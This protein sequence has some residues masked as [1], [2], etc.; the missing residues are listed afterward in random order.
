MAS[1]DFASCVLK[2]TE[3]Y[4]QHDKKTAGKLDDLLKRLS[5]PRNSQAL[6][7]TVDLS[8]PI[9]HYY[10]SSSHN[11]YLTGNQLW[12]KSSTTAYKEVLKRGCRCIE[13]DV[14]DGGS[15]SNS[16][17]SSSS[18]NDDTGS[19]KET[20]DVN[21][22]TGM[23]QK[24]L[25]R[26]RSN[27]AKQDD[28][29]AESATPDKDE[30]LMPAPWRVLSDREEP[31]V[32]HGYTATKEITFRSVCEVV[33]DYAFVS[34]DLPLIVSLEVH[35]S[36][37]Q[38]AVMVEIMV[39]YWK[40]LLVPVP[41]GFS[42]ETALPPLSDLKNKILIKVKYSPP[43][44]KHRKHHPDKDEDEEDQ[45]GPAA[46]GKII[47]ELSQLGVY[48]RSCHFDSL[49]QPEAKMP[50]HIF[51]LSESKII[52]LLE[53]NRQGLFDHNLNYFMRAYPKGTR[54]RSTNLDPGP[55][56]RQGIQI[57]ALN[58]QQMNAAMMM[59]YA[60]FADTGGWV[61]KPTGYL[62]T[63]DG[64]VPPVKRIGFDLTIRLL[65]A[66]NLDAEKSSPPN[67]YIKAEIH[68][69]SEAEI[70]AGSIPKGGKNK[71]GEWKR[72]SAVHQSKNPDFDGETL[73]FKG[74]AGVIPELSFIRYV[75]E[76]L[77]LRP[78]WDQ[79]HRAP[80]THAHKMLDAFKHKLF[81]R[82]GL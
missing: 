50:T 39:D 29:K 51:A 81:R 66:Q 48:V 1:A 33:R 10:V 24:G 9:S 79:L 23:L 26:I 38:Q 35:C 68:N 59:N 77:L 65:A 53:D 52:S 58:W 28:N 74:V 11:T 55:F 7:V 75:Q 34:T 3:R 45:V 32:Y 36:H 6:P 21:T 54:I 46:K 78:V 80:V 31:R 5:D 61:K 25:G 70:E 69:E 14:W 18:E 44:K 27:E 82:P 2:H 13:V 76:F 49:D 42:D 56:W 67:V 30:A 8:D 40:Q 37:E 64:T 12:S 16:H 71:G 22:L 17:S 43:K 41:P 57:V 4:F 20:A 15:P 60:M 73:E 19:T 62:P 63:K 72:K 47:P